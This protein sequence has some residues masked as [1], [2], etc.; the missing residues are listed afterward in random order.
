[1]LKFKPSYRFLLDLIVLA[2]SVYFIGFLLDAWRSFPVPR[3]CD[4]I[5][6]L[7]KVNFI[8]N[9][10]PHIFWNY[11]WAGGMPMFRWYPPS[12]YYVIAAFTALTN[13]RA[14]FVMVVF[15][16]ILYF[17]ASVGVYGLMLGVTRSR[18]ISILTSLF[19]LSSPS[20]WD[21]HILGGAHARVASLLLLPLSMW[22][23]KRLTD[24]FAE[25]RPSKLSYV[26]T[27]LLLAF[28]VS[29]NPFMGWPALLLSLL[30]PLFYLEGWRQKVY[31]AIKIFIPVLSLNAYFYVP[32][33]YAPLRVV[34]E[35]DVPPKNF[36]LQTPTSGS[37]LALSPIHVALTAVFLAIVVV[38]KLGAPSR[39]ENKFLKFCVM[40][41]SLFICFVFLGAYVESIYPFAGL[42]ICIMP[43]FLMPLAGSLLHRIFRRI[44]RYAKPAFV[45]LLLVIILSVHMLPGVNIVTKFTS[46]PPALRDMLEE[47]YQKLNID[48]PQTMYRVGIYGADG[49]LGQWWNYK[50]NVPQT[51]DYFFQ[52]IAYPDW[53]AWLHD[54]VWGRLNNYEEAN[55]LL[56][57]WAVKWILVDSITSDPGKFLSRSDY[58]D[59]AVNVNSLHEF[60][61]KNPTPIASA[62]NAPSLLVISE[63]APPG[64]GLYRCILNDLAYSDYNS[65][66]VIPVHGGE[67][68]DDYFLEELKRFDAVIMYGYKYHDLTTAWELLQEYV[69]GGGGLIIETGLQYRSPDWNASYI[70]PP[71]P[72]DR[73]YWTNFG[74]DW[75]FSFVDSPVTDGINFTAFSPA[76]SEGAVWGVSSSFNESVRE[77]ARPVLWDNG[78]PLIVTGEYGKGRVV[79]SGM[80]LPWHIAVYKNHEESR[81]LA[82]I[83]DWVSKAPGK[84]RIRVDYE[85]KRVNPEKVV[86][87]VHNTSNGVL[88]KE[89]FFKDWRA[90][91]EKDGKRIERLR[92]HKAGPDFM[93]VAIPK[94]AEYPV[95]ILFELSKLVEYVGFSISA[96]TLFTLLAYGFIGEKLTAPF[97]HTTEKMKR[98]I[99]DWWHEE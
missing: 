6:Q 16:Y 4:A 21:Q 5:A 46:P 81:F 35:S 7:H 50:S 95:T 9:F 32:F 1:M 67:Y 36:L 77:W 55:F 69:Q 97:T 53:F 59:S 43:L 44:Q 94:N 28:T 29:F 8:L 20:V 76:V 15:L 14:E 27:V 82:K 51:R 98:K 39:D 45:I 37:Y 3:G 38:L 71:C 30:I 47:T 41:V 58:Y 66:Y 60:I 87:T 89:F 40:V 74:M 13:Y 80:N 57:W 23:T 22:L 25:G 86:V 70:P 49:W 2:I 19:V 42:V 18:Q 72:V 83:V 33:L 93:Y 68:I 26:C 92:V 31:T 90:F 12:F 11:Q 10:W 84:R 79:W 78:H 75:H 99:K 34:A 52:G 96:V 85:A 61:Y 88:F 48:D 65:R 73:T 91:L 56:D 64:G 54:A 24:N 63:D 62:T 17:L